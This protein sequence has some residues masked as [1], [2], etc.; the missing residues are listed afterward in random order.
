MEDSVNMREA[1][2]L[3]SIQMTISR[4]RVCTPGTYPCLRTARCGEISPAWP[5]MHAT[6]YVSSTTF[7]ITPTIPDLQPDNATKIAP[8][9]SPG[10]RSTLGR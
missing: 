7:A 9:S 1:Y 4:G 6:A 2:I 3:V 10:S 8:V 5:L